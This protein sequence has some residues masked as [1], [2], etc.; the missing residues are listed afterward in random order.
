MLPTSRLS[1]SLFCFYQRPVGLLRRIH[2]QSRCVS[3]LVFPIQQGINRLGSR[4]SCILQQAGLRRTSLEHNAHPFTQCRGI[5]SSV[6]C[7]ANLPKTAKDIVRR[8]KKGRFLC[9]CISAAYLDSNIESLHTPEGKMKHQ[10]LCRGRDHH[11]C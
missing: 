7:T 10:S 3:T 2:G 6:V 9:A 1:W 5:R 11:I 4:N 8:L